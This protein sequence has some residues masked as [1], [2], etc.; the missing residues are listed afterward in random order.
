MSPWRCRFEQIGDYRVITQ[1][2][3][4][5][6]HS[7]SINQPWRIAVSQRAQ[8]RTHCA[9]K[10]G[11]PPSASIFVIARRWMKHRNRKR[12]E[13][14]KKVKLGE[15]KGEWIAYTTHWAVTIKINFD[16]NQHAITIN[17]N[18]HRIR[19]VRLMHSI[20]ENVTSA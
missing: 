3:K 10:R 14:R 2:S 17:K 13:A 4:T 8:Q 7:R 5:H 19:V 9:S 16:R 12:Q 15:I 6:F 20:A 18:R 11:T 1:R